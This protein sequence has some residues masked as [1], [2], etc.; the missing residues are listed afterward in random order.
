MRP[1]PKFAPTKFEIFAGKVAAN[2]PRYKTKQACSVMLRRV[3]AAWSAAGS[4]GNVKHLLDR[5]V[6]AC[7]DRWQEL[8]GIEAD[9]R[10]AQLAGVSDVA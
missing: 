6:A 2:A 5:A 9:A 4:Y 1:S 3:R 7:Q 8:H 10:F